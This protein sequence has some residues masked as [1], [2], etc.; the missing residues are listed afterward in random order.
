MKR[1]YSTLEIKAV[2]DAGDGKK[3]TFTGIAS[4][5]T[6]DRMADIVE[7]KGAQFKLP[8]PLLWQH[9]SRQ[10][11]GWVTAA[12]V[13]DKGIE[14]EGEVADIP[15][16][17]KLKDRLAEAWQS[18]KNKLVRGLSIGFD[19]IEHTKIDGTWGYRYTK[20]EW[21]E[22]SAV[23]IPANSDCSINAI[24]S[25]DQAV[26]RAASGRKDFTVVRLNTVAPATT[27]KG[28]K[29]VTLPGASGPKSTEN[30]KGNDMNIAEQLLAFDTKRK[31]AIDRM[32][33]IMSKSAEAGSTLDE[34][35]TEEYDGLDAEVK[36]IDAHIERLTA[37]EKTMVARAKAVTA[38][39]DRP[40]GGVQIRGTGPIT[41]TRNLPKGTAFTRY[42]MALAA[43][44]GNLMQA[45][46]LAE[47]WK[48]TPEVGMVLKAAVAAGTTSDATWAAPLVQYEN[49]QSEFIEL[50]RPLTILGRLNS[51]RR[52]P[53]NVRIPRQTGGTSGTF[54]GEGAPA[55]VKKLDFDNV[56]LPWAKASTIVVLT[57][58]L[59]RMSNPSAEALVR[60][61]LLEGC[62]EYLDK[63]FVDPAY[64]GVANVSPAS[65]TN[66]V[67]VR[68]ASG[69][70]LAAIDDDVG[71]VMKQF[72]AANLT[73]TS[74]VWIMSPGMAINLSLLRTNQ[75][76][77]AFP[78]INMNGGTWYGLPV[79]TSN[80][81][82]PSGSPGDEQILLI[83]QREILLADDGQ[84]LLDVSTEASLQMNDAPSGGATS[85][86][87]L[88]QNG[89]LGVKV[90]RWIYWTKRRAQAA[91]I[92]DGAQRY[93]S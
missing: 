55:P 90:D 93:G 41:V 21:L 52:V 73:L 56:T 53:F 30:P 82:A 50:L 76:T 36:S 23:T 79:I 87:S 54:V 67:T 64:P 80:S 88:W 6:V 85:L 20:W 7:P 16:D 2:D 47:R 40:E 39:T 62:A 9:D 65:V 77:K 33:A 60:Q 15:E 13:T 69:A 63:R 31:A 34:H 35:E 83:D 78:D 8:I 24:K 46:R 92:I 49:M 28:I 48:D 74:G 37:H 57:A 11:I 1:A 44:K 68:Q 66:G 45:E 75:D 17:G 43:A 3:R 19:P 22:L 81:M 38:D 61:D 10:P 70:S 89:M 59:A 18:I 12:K 14:I 84:M 58:E 72:T 71:Y 5:P 91:Q 4:T 32:E 26:L 27:T 86:V 25:A 29:P 42:T 51:L